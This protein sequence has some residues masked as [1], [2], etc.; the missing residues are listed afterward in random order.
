MSQ[1]IIRTGTQQKIKPLRVVLTTYYSLIVI[2]VSQFLVRN[3]LI[4]TLHVTSPPSPTRW[5][6][7]ICQTNLPT[8]ASHH[9]INLKLQL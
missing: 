5:P 9:T 3:P 6:S 1:S 8:H 2:A 4:S 7:Q